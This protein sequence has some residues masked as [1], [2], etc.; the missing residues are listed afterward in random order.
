[1]V[2][3]QVMLMVEAGELGLDDSVADHLP[4]I[5][6]ATAAASP[7]T[8]TCWRTARRPSPSGSGRRPRSWSCCQPSGLLPVAASPTRRPT[9]CCSA[10]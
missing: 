8:T 7:T 2:A 10:S 1:V 3:A 6:S 9:T 5:C 4:D